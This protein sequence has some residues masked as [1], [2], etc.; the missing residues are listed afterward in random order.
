MLVSC[1]I[2]R[3]S[4]KKIRVCH[5]CVGKPA[6]HSKYPL[7]IRTQYT[8]KERRI[9]HGLQSPPGTTRRS[10]TRSLQTVCT[11]SHKAEHAGTRRSM[12]TQA[13]AHIRTH[14]STKGPKTSHIKLNNDAQFKK[15]R[16][17][18]LCSDTEGPNVLR[19][20]KNED[21]WSLN[22][23]TQQDVLTFFPHPEV[24]DAQ[25]MSRAGLNR[26]AGGS[27][28]PLHPLWPR[29]RKLLA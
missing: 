18:K 20:Q 12:N 11:M 24:N 10:S 9:G 26:K 25:A 27:D 13:R 8:L 17:N 19:I 29:A 2:F 7:N 21:N 22:F 23:R 28:P 1:Q 5:F 4:T 3:R 16:P 15:T 14:M 6:L